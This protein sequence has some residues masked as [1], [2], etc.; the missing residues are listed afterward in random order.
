MSKKLVLAGGGHAHMMLLANLKTLTANGHLVTV[1]QPSDFH[2]YSGMGPG[3]LSTVY[4]PDDIRFNTRFVV[5]RQGAEFVKDR[6]STIDATAQMITTETGATLSYDVLSCNTGSFVPFGNIEGDAVNIFSAKPIERLLE[7][8]HKIVSLCKSGAIS[9][10]V[11]GGGPAAVELA[12]N[13]CHLAHSTGCKNIEVRLFAG[14]KMMSHFSSAIQRII[15]RNFT[16]RGII[17]DQ[18]GYVDKIADGTLFLENGERYTPDIIFPATGVK[19]STVF[20]SSG[21]PT[22]PDGGL[23]VNSFLQSNDY[24]SI[25]GGGDC[26]YYDPEPL[27][28]VGVYAVRQNPVLLHNV[29]ASMNE[30]PLHPFDPG[31]GYLLIFNLGEK[32]GALQKGP[33]TWGGKGAFI[34]K[35]YLDR[36]FIKKFQALEA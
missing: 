5:E 19:P 17:I 4:R 32:R 10:G 23:R 30:T 21:I 8:Q 11:I 13:A 1:I 12:G 22:G 29:V 26:I 27:D 24:H 31:G 25:F 7:A 16:R 35:D 28:K 2:Y 14:K 36:K 20:T 33:F 3:M 9:I 6:V 18:S 15:R 34:V